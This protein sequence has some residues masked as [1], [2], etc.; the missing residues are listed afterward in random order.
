MAK[1]AQDARLQIV[2]LLQNQL[3][4][5]DGFELRSGSFYGLFNDV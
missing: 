1:G 4:D 2:P 5:G 3:V